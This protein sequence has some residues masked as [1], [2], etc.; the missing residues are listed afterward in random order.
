MATDRARD[1]ELAETFAQVARTLLGDVVVDIAATLKRICSLAVTT[2]DSCETAGISIVEDQRIMSRSTTNDLPRILDEI[3]TQ[4]QQGP[5]IDAI[6]VDQVVRTDALSR[7]RRWP[8]FAGRAHA[9][10]RVES[11]LSL[12][13]YAQE[14]TMGSL[15]LYSS[16]PDAFD[17]HEVALASVFAPMPPSPCRP[18]G[19][20]ASSRRSR[21]AGT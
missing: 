10:T 13:L 17:D 14:D 11:V 4:T 21:P 16:L 8:D 15:N 3:Q 12:R 1:V 6:K 9:E 5:G 20:K 7:E 2:I 19:A 18:L